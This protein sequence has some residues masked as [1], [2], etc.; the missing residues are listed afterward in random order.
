[1]GIVK[2]SVCIF[3]RHCSSFYRRNL[4]QSWRTACAED[5]NLKTAFCIFFLNLSLVL[6]W[7]ASQY[8]S[9]SVPRV[10][11]SP[12]FSYTLFASIYL[13]WSLCLFSPFVKFSLCVTWFH[14]ILLCSSLCSPF[15]PSHPHFARLTARLLWSRSHSV[16]KRHRDIPWH[17]NFGATVLYW[18]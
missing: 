2:L 12:S 11:R 4:I 9:F 16:H 10:L 6:P 15:L 17:L 7:L 18:N 1:M 3:N 13:L 8:L 5:L 14:V